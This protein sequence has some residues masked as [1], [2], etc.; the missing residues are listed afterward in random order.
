MWPPL[1]PGLRDSG[2]RGPRPMAATW[3]GFMRTINGSCFSIG[4]LTKPPSWQKGFI[5]WPE[6][7]RDSQYVY[8]IMSRSTHP[9][10][11]KVVRVRISDRKLEEIKN[12][13][14]A[15]PADRILHQ[16][17]GAGSR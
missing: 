16:L 13:E 10:Y 5:S 8:F 9:R 3:P 14:D 17:V 11:D 6:W 2:R 4:K 12:V 15:H 7:S 1:F